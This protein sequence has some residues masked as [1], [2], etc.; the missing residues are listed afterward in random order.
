MPSIPVNSFNVGQDLQN[1]ILTIN[2]LTFPFSLIGHLD[3]INA[4]QKE[5]ELEEISVTGGGL[6]ILRNLYHGWEGDLHFTRFNGT[7]TGIITGII[8]QFQ[9]TGQETIITI[10]GLVANSV[11]NTTDPF[12]FTGVVFS[13]G[14]FGGFRGT[15]KVEQTVRFRAQSLSWNG[16]SAG[17]LQTGLASLTNV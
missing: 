13:K 1:P 8:N 2:G 6:P 4:T 3:D 5:T 11:L 10:S 12:A 16:P 7:L 17:V 14:S 15:S 9:S